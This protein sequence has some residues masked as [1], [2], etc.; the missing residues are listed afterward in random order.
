MGGGMT[1]KELLHHGLAGFMR[2]N[3]MDVST[4]LSDGTIVLAID[5]KYR[6]FCRQAPFGDLVLEVQLCQ[7]PDQIEAANDWIVKALQRSWSRIRDFSD[8]PVLSEDSNYI[9]LHQRITADATV[10]EFEKSLEEFVSSLIDWR[11]NFGLL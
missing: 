2:R 7:L 10:D 9:F 11:R 1:A 5:D 3:S 4:A 8:V 6:I